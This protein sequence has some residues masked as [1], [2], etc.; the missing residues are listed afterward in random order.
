MNQTLGTTEI[1]GSMSPSSR[2]NS[3]FKFNKNLGN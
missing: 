2:D 1:Y 3:I